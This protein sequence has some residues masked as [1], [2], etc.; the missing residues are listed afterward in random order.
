MHGRMIRHGCAIGILTAT[1]TA[2][3]TTVGYWRFDEGPAYSAA[4]GAAGSVLDSTI[5]HLNLTP[6]GQPVY[7]SDRPITPIPQTGAANKLSLEFNAASQGSSGTQRL[8]IADSPLLE[9]TH[10][11]TLEAYVNVFSL[12][13]GADAES[14][15]V[16]RGDDRGGLD[17]YFLEL[18]GSDVRFEINSADGQGAS[19]SAALP[20]VHQ[21]V[22]LA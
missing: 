6:F 19:V 10:S 22:N 18:H 4:G 21:W 8:D 17:P 1:S 11:L 3:A 15:I 13:Q 14:Q 12:P 16:F 20:V 7:R 2:F 9:L 5:H